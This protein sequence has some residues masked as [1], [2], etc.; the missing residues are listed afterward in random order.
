MTPTATDNI[1]HD[2]AALPSEELPLPKNE[3]PIYQRW[4]ATKTKKSAR[5]LSAKEAN[6]A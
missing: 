1:T 2:V 3:V 4:A 6:V 5:A